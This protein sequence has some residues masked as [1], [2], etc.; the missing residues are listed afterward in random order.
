MGILPTSFHVIGAVD[1]VRVAVAV[2]RGVGVARWVGAD[3][4]VGPGVHVVA[5]V[6]ATVAACVGRGAGDDVVVVG[7]GTSDAVPGVAV[8]R[9]VA[10]L[11]GPAVGA[12]G[13]GGAVGRVVEQPPRRNRRKRDA[14]GHFVFMVPPPLHPGV[15]AR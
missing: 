4:G 13:V 5:S 2:G 12:D 14:A 6:G 1:G 7:S 11:V 10:A 9:D 15:P 8:L 3:V